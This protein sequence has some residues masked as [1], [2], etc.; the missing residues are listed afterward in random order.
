MLLLARLH[1][2]HFDCSEYGLSVPD[3]KR[4]QIYMTPAQLNVMHAHKCEN[5]ALNGVNT[6]WIHGDCQQGSEI[7]H[8]CPRCGQT[9]QWVST[10]LLVGKIPSE[11]PQR[12]GK[13]AQA[14]GAVRVIPVTSIWIILLLFLAVAVYAFAFYKFYQSAKK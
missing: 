7:A 6:I 1:H 5:C 11:Q 9:K 14:Q 8:T 13:Q 12:P 10:P 2:K 4:T 3:Q